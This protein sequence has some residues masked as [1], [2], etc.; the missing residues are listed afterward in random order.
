MCLPNLE[1]GFPSHFANKYP[2]FPDKFHCKKHP[3]EDEKTEESNYQAKQKRNITSASLKH[4]NSITSLTF[5]LYV[6]QRTYSGTRMK[7]NDFKYV[8]PFLDVTEKD[9]ISLKLQKVP[10]FA[11]NPLR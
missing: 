11:N 1:D 6:F 5:P 10:N 4:L 2:F 8:V 7:T 3:T 9:L